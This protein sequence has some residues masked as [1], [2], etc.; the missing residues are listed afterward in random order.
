[1]QIQSQAQLAL[2][3][4]IKKKAKNVFD[5]FM[6]W[7]MYIKFDGFVT[8]NRWMP[9]IVWAWSLKDALSENNKNKIIK[10]EL[11]ADYIK[12]W[13][14]MDDAEKEANKLISTKVKQ[15]LISAWY[16]ILLTECV[17][18]DQNTRQI[19]WIYDKEFYDLLM[20]AKKDNKL[21]EVVNWS[22]AQF[23]I[24]TNNI[25]ANENQSLSSWIS[26]WVNYNLSTVTKKLMNYAKRQFDSQIKSRYS[27][28]KIR[29]SPKN[30][31]YNWVNY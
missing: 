25:L 9:N 16:T 10:K 24:M 19:T 15:Q 26:G 22:L 23:S 8:I 28:E 13:Y 4:H 20:W 14:K 21:L 27:S 5:K 1:M 29:L 17:Q 3:W 2:L 31:K 7:T 18:I 11:I 30:A 6:W 12:K